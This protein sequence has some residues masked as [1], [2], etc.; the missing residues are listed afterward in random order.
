MRISANKE[1]R[2]LNKAL[3]A[4]TEKRRKIERI[5]RESEKRLNKSQEI[6]HLGS[7]ELDVAGNRLYWSDE[8]YRIFG[9][10]PQEFKATYEAFLERVHPDDRKAVDKAYSMSLREGRGSYEIEHRIIKKSTGEIRY[11][12]EKCQHIRDASGKVIRSLGMAHDITERRLAEEALNNERRNLRTIIDNIPGYIYFKDVKSRFITAN[13]ATARVMRSKTP[14]NLIG[15]TD[16][17]FYPKKF[18]DKFYRDEQ[19]ILATGKAKIDMEESIVDENNQPRIISTS[20][21]PLHDIRGK[22]IGLAGIG[23]DI[24]RRKRTEEALK[25]A[26]SLL[27]TKVAQ[28]TEELVESN[29]HLI[30]EI[31]ERKAIERIIRAR[32]AISKII[33]RSSNRKEFLDTLV[34]LIKG[35]TGC[36]YVG[37]RVLSEGGEIPYESY[38]GF[39]R[40]FWEKENW[41]SIKRDQCACIRVV[42]GNPLPQDA[43]CMTKAGSFVSNSALDFVESLT[44]E[45]KGLFRGVCIQNG[46]R[47]VAVIPISYR[48][49]ILGVF[50]LADERKDMFPSST[51]E[52]IEML[53][54][55]IGEGVYKFTLLEKIQKSNQL[56]EQVKRLSD[57]GSLA[58][59]VAHELRNPLG[60]IRTAAYNIKRKAQNPLLEGHLANIEKKIIEADQ[61]INNLLF[62]SRLK[63]PHIERVELFSI[64]KES[65]EHLKNKSPR[66]AVGKKISSIKGDFI[67]ADPL[68]LGE[69][70]N[71]ILGNAHDAFTGDKG[72]IEVAAWKDNSGNIVVQ[73]KDYGA[74]MDSE[75]LSRIFEPF[76]TTKAK[77]TGLGLTVCKQ[78]VTLHNGAIGF[79]SEKGRGT[80]VTV[81][82]PLRR[83]VA[84]ADINS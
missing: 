79:E 4:E 81:T 36:R 46:F 70:F 77:G 21:V 37:V 47:S 58:A 72:R 74:G 35:L 8:A 57:I 48:S 52:L 2:A 80:T 64:L 65:I 34:K 84:P 32:S 7:W 68:Q 82:L 15:K 76:Y 62:Y 73:V 19:E 78:I 66:C 55:L 42:A 54:A 53:T 24:T 83:K 27:E 16:F 30:R 14:E 50:H 25:Q 56:L 23:I 43:P 17:D 9:L 3:R 60:V 10:K 69:L 13:A 12:H 49:E 31:S 5:L 75:Q 67:E 59:T 33:Q 26:Y 1:I 20:K 18:A 63:L 44:E 22:I 38:I 29:R 71:N 11:I 6:A 41:L 28:R 51:I 61:I 40:D 45:E 39:S